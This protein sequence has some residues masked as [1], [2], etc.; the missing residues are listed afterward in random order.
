MQMT[1]VIAALRSMPRSTPGSDYRERT[2]ALTASGGTVVQTR[3]L[4][5]SA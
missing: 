2:A 3:L 5:C 4:T 1:P